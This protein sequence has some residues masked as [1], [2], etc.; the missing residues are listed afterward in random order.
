MIFPL[1]THQI[2][3]HYLGF[4]SSSHHQYNLYDPFTDFIS[5]QPTDKLLNQ[6]MLISYQVLYLEVSFLTQIALL[7]D[8]YSL[9]SIHLIFEVINTYY[10]LIL[11]IFE[12]QFPIILEIIFLQFILNLSNLLLF[13]FL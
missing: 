10:L 2:L 12:L 1:L 6:S 7:F 4:S 11:Y 9:S 13:R 8:L 5:P 3:I